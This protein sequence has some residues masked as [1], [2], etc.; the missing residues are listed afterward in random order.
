M[1]ARRIEKVCDGC[2]MEGKCKR[3]P[4]WHEDTERYDCSEY[5]EEDKA[6]TVMGFS[7]RLNELIYIK[8]DYTVED[9]A[10]A[11]Q[12]NRCTIYRYLEGSSSPNIVIFNRLCSFLRVS[13]NYLLRG[14]E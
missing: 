4:D 11:V 3:F 9:V 1:E 14:K 10:R 12:V 7:E 8:N 2:T 5:Q 13:P 6:S